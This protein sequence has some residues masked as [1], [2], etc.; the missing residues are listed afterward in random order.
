MQTGA[1]RGWMLAGSALFLAV[2]R[3]AAADSA[4]VTP[5]QCNAAYEKSQVLRRANKLRAARDELLVCSQVTCPGA[6]T[7]DCGPWLRE[8]EGGMPTV[9]IAARDPSGVDVPAV[10]VSVDGVLLTPRL[11]GAPLEV[12]PGSHTL[13]FEPE[14]GARVE[15]AVLINVGE[16]NRLI[17]VTVRPEAPPPPGASP[18]KPAEPQPGAPGEARKGSWVPG[19][20]IGAVGVVSLAVS[21]GVYFN[22]NSSA[23]NLRATCAPNCS[24]S[25][26]DSVRAQGVVSD[27]TFGVGIVGIGVGAVLMILLHPTRAPA[28][29]ALS[30]VVTPVRG[31]AITGFA[32]RF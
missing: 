21:F 20:T 17:Q 1:F 26:V 29:T 15:Q 4:A 5:Q 7:A 12:D 19:I 25:Q 32:A 30:P 31:G 18:P 24:S 9:V 27:V 14:H 3:S 8:V 28:S 16:K 6:I 13:A 23:D 22:A 11:T 2:P 10:K